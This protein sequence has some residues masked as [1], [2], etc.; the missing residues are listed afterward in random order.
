MA[1]LSHPAGYSSIAQLPSKASGA[2][3][4]Q[5]RQMPQSPKNAPWIEFAELSA[6][7]LDERSNVRPRRHGVTLPVVF[8]TGYKRCRLRKLKCPAEPDRVR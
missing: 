7:T 5:A 8:L 6:E 3:L 2:S 4:H 1:I